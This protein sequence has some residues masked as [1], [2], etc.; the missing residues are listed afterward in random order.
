MSAAVLRSVACGER[1]GLGSLG[2][3]GGKGTP[4]WTGVFWKCQPYFSHSDRER[5]FVWDEFLRRRETMIALRGNK[6]CIERQ[7]GKCACVLCLA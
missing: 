4:K 2:N 7:L 3:K 5:N 6:T 1:L